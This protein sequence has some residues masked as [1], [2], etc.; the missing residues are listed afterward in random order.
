M[1]R[2]PLRIPTPHQACELA[3]LDEDKVKSIH[4]RLVDRW[5]EIE[6]FEARAMKCT[7]EYSWPECVEGAS[8]DVFDNLGPVVI[9]VAK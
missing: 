7:I 3:S 6:G 4:E 1:E 5:S 2:L 9:H 8:E